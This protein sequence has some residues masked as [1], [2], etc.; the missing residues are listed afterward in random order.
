MERSHLFPSYSV[1]AFVSFC[2]EVLTCLERVMLQVVL[3]GYRKQDHWLKNPSHS[4]LLKLCSQHFFCGKIDQ[5]ICLL[6]LKFFT[7]N[8]HSVYYFREHNYFSKNRFE[9]KM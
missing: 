3:R 9:K 4:R 6:G 1:T 7:S 8:N 2:I 5:F